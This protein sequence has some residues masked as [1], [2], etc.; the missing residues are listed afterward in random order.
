MPSQKTI[1]ILLNDSQRRA[2]TH[3]QGHLLIIAG[4]GTGKTHTLTQRIIYLLD[5][6]QED[7][8][9]LAVTFTNKA[10]E[11]MKERLAHV[12]AASPVPP[13]GWNRVD[14]GTF[15]HFCLKLL[16]ERPHLTGLP[17]NFQVASREDVDSL[18][19]R[20][21]AEAT[22]KERSGK[23]EA[24]AL[25]KGTSLD[26]EE[27]PDVST[28]NGFLR[29][30]SFLDFDD[31]LREAVRLLETNERARRAIRQTYR[32]ICVDEYQDVNPVQH[33]LL[34]LL[35]G[36]KTLVTAIGD[37]NQ[38]IYGF[39]GGHVRFFE[40]FPKDFSGTEVLQLS[41]NYRSAPELL[42][43][44][45]QIIRDQGFRVPELTARLYLK[46]QL[47]IFEAP[48]EKAEAEY[49][50]HTIEKMVGGTSM[51]SQDSGRVGSGE[52]AQR[53]FG[54]IAVLYRL[55]CQRKAL[56]EAF[57]RSGI[58][59]QTSGERPLEETVDFKAEKVNLMTLHAAKGLEFPVVFI[60]GCEENIIPLRLQ[61]LKADAQEERRLFYV[62]MTRA[63]EALYLIRSKRRM[64]YGKKY[65][66]GPSPFLK[67]IE[68][69]LKSYETTQTL[70]KRCTKSSEKQL[71]LFE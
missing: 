20:L 39:R 43:A 18:L 46:G 24:V 45:G 59:Y 10:A 48:T 28:Y 71:S 35:V 11:Q 53:S 1:P 55:N 37:P 26:Q 49:V 33:R 50:V 8:R 44:S 51:F 31:L 66:G 7:E 65:A 19:K 30:H 58:P 61:G 9:I 64:L 29:E 38:A 60:A 15:H 3:E 52:D 42:K 63:K 34:K 23:L 4:P 47:H 70:S 12:D 54:D 68:E 6:L 17:E 69:E 40:T 62:G 27:P 2:V 32:F 57:G 25:W 56:E 21:W 14:V 16:K 41:D 36:E 67:D 5:R 13:Q 22:A